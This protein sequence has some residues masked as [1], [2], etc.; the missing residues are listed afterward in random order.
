MCITFLLVWK[1]TFFEVE[2]TTTLHFSEKLLERI[3]NV[4]LIPVREP[5]FVGTSGTNSIELE[6]VGKQAPVSANPRLTRGMSVNI[7]SNLAGW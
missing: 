2:Q 1:R 5:V 3:Q 6:R 7:D 4:L